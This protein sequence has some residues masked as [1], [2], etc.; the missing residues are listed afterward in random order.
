M[1]IDSTPSRGGWIFLLS[2]DTVAHRR[3]TFEIDQLVFRNGFQDNTANGTARLRVARYWFSL[4]TYLLDSA[5]PP[6][7]SSL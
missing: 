3:E 1:R 5:R 2:R 7:L 6:F 4:A